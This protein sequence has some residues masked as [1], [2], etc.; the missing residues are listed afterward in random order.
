MT[1][2]TTSKKA[3]AASLTALAL[4]LSLSA[5]GEKEDTASG[6]LSTAAT[7]PGAATAD[8]AAGET[9]DAVAAEETAAAED[10]AKAEESKDGKESKEPKS[11]AAKTTSKAPANN[12]NPG[13]AAG[14]AVP[15]IANPFE[16]GQVEIPT[17][18]PI[19]TGKEGSEA[20]RKQMED[21]VRKVTNPDSFAT[22]T[23]TILDN[24]CAAVRQ[25]ALEEFE[26]Q[27]LTLDM[28]EQMMRAQ[29]AQGGTINIPKTDV[30]VTDVRID[31]NR[32]SA[33]VSTSNSE[34]NAS[35]VQLFAKED[36]RW[37]VCN[38]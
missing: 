13:A 12:Q 16:N 29:E 38:G 23:R 21:V 27:G 8:V 31:G 26:R 6:G 14:G 30:K 37:K 7:A 22:W 15:T 32:A 18:E 35:Q 20:D 4:A 5:C 1:L 19:T 17:Y 3:A 25:P 10:T 28:V 36:G 11:S 34:G 9:T 24:S 33:T 2:T